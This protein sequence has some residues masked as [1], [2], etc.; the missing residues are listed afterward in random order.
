MDLYDSVHPNAIPA[1]APAVAGYD[2][3]TQSQWSAEGWARWRDV[4][5]LHITVLADERSEVFDVE[6]GNAPAG[7]VA[8][9]VSGRLQAGEWS[10]VY[11]SESSF[12]DVVR[13]LAA[14]SMR[15]SD[16]SQFPAPGVYLWAADPSGNIAAGRWRPPADPVA[17]QDRY[18]GSYDISTCAVTLPG[19]APA[20]P[21]GPGDE[22]EAMTGWTDPDGTVHVAGKA[23]DDGHLL[24]FSRLSNGRWVVDDVTDVI[25]AEAPA[26]QRTY[27]IS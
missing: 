23:N 27:S 9:A 24:V 13:A 17:V 14:K 21:T 22:E 15:F 12:G 5:Q 18:E 3:G 26:D 6:G 4:P 11:C 25:H 1:D 7:E 19:R 16:A 8:A 2:D 20:Q 10:W